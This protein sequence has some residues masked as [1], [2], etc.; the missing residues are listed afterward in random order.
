MTPRFSRVAAAALLLGVPLAATAHDGVHVHDA[1]AIVSP[2]GTSG[3]A[4][5]LIDN[6]GAE[7]DRLVAARSEV[8]ERVELH[9]HIEDAAGVMRMVEVE[10]GFAIPA[11]GERLLARGGDHVMFLGLR[12]APAEGDSITVTLVFERE[13]EVTVEVPVRAPGMEAPGHD[14]GHSHGHSHGHGN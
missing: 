2:A 11:G 14:H 6:H 7:D 4:F 3:A 5:M 12:H 9:T 10:E 8:S 13:G 1:F